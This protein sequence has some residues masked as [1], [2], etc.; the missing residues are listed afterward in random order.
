MSSAPLLHL[1]SNFHC[2]FGKNKTKRQP[3]HP[4]VT[5]LWFVKTQTSCV[6]SIVWLKYY[7]EKINFALKTLDKTYCRRWITGVFSSIYSL[8]PFSWGCD[9]SLGYQRLNNKQHQSPCLSKAAWI[10]VSHMPNKYFRSNLQPVC[11]F[12]QH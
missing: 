9:F 10:C 2:L 12:N 11:F 5:K 4:P 8:L 1:I 7:H 6:C 3:N